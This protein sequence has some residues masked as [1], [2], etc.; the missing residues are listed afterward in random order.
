MKLQYTTVISYYLRWLMN[1]W[2]F[3]SETTKL[4]SF[5]TRESCHAH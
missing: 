3:V 2:K 4:C 5:G 1:E